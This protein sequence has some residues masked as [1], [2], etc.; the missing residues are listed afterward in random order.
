MGATHT[1]ITPSAA[2]SQLSHRPSGDSTGSSRLGLPN[3]VLRGM[4]GV[5][6]LG[7]E[8]KSFW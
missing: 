1:F 8:A 4:S 7:I 6:A 2:A 3:S 5:S